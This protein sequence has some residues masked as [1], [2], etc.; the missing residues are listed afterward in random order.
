MR[1][2]T[3]SKSLLRVMMD[4]V[5]VDTE[6]PALGA[7]KLLRICCTHLYIYCWMTQ[8]LT[9]RTKI[10]TIPRPRHFT[11]GARCYGRG[12]LDRGWLNRFLKGGVGLFSV[13]RLSLSKLLVSRSHVVKRT[14]TPL[15][16]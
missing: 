6:L 3:P 5:G 1:E 10:I 13:V 11:S 7:H 8:R 2:R 4:D 9:L 14:N 15:I 16:P 12:V